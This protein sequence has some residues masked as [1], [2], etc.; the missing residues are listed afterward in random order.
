[1]SDDEVQLRHLYHECFHDDPAFED[2][3]F[4]HLYSRSHSTVMKRKGQ[5]VSGLLYADCGLNVASGLEHE[6]GAVYLSG[7]CTHPD[8]RGQGMASEIICRTLRKCLRAGEG[9]AAL[10]P[11][12]AGLAEFYARLGFAPCFDY[13]EETY[14]PSPEELALPDLLASAHT[15]VGVEFAE[16]ADYLYEGLPSA[17][18]CFY[19]GTASGLTTTLYYTDMRV[20]TRGYLFGD[21]A[22]H[23]LRIEDIHLYGG[24]VWKIASRQQEIVAEAIVYPRESQLLVTSLVCDNVQARMYMLSLLAAHYGSPE[25]HIIRPPRLFTPLN[26]TPIGLEG[27]LAEGEQDG[28][29]TAWVSRRGHSAYSEVR[30]LGMARVVDVDEVMLTVAEAYPEIET[31]FSL[32]DEQLPENNGTFVFPGDGTVHLSKRSRVP[33][34]SVGQLT[35]ALIGYH[36]SSLPEPLRCFPAGIPYMHTMLNK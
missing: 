28:I 35:Q 4:R 5:I 30:H 2:A 18:L 31:S 33:Q 24:M 27:E 25:I 11:A 16:P 15:E 7:V 29:A 22:F 10:I 21:D 23:D 9:Y 32:V 17:P 20:L 6:I 36:T 1:M 14:Y 13:V 3:Y 12:D 19:H 34:V 8:F 26:G